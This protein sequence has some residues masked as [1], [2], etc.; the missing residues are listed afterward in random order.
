LLIEE[1]DRLPTVAV[2]RALPQCDGQ[3]RAVGG[4]QGEQ[5]GKRP[6]IHRIIVSTL[7][8]ELQG[9]EPIGAFDP[10]VKIGNPVTFAFAAQRTG[11]VRR[12]D[13]GEQRLLVTKKTAKK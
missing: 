2:S 1:L 12:I 6:R 5:L 7:R 9:L 10:A 8:L 4:G 11:F 13:G 3:F